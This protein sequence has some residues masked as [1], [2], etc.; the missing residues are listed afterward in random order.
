MCPEFPVGEADLVGQGMPTLK[1]WVLL[2]S[3]DLFPIEQRNTSGK[4]LMQS[5]SVNRSSAVPVCKISCTYVVL[6]A[7]N[8]FL[9][10]VLGSI[11]FTVPGMEVLFIV[12]WNEGSNIHEVVFDLKDPNQDLYDAMYIDNKTA[13]VVH[14]Y[15]EAGE[16]PA[17][18]S[19]CNLLDCIDVSC[20]KK[21]A[22][23]VCLICLISF[24]SCSEFVEL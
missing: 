20:D 2:I 17:T 8:C 12:H 15:S 1:K 10:F 14:A 4:I 22:L 7:S 6:V 19:V 9:I 11:N 5:F 23:L 24:M 21:T 18:V 3:V 16:Y 13:S